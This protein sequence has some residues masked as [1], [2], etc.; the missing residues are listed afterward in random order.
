MFAPWFCLS[1]RG[2]VLSSLVSF[3]SEVRLVSARAERG[4]GGRK[5]RTEAERGASAVVSAA[6]EDGWDW[7]ASAAIC[8]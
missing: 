6:Q 7:N 2:F 3:R 1:E 4:E 5:K 8:H